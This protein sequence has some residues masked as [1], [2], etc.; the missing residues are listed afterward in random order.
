MFLK[1]LLTLLALS[2]APHS[3]LGIASPELL[4]SS[5]DT[6]LNT[7]GHLAL[8]DTSPN[9]ALLMSRDISDETSPQLTPR[10]TLTASCNIFTASSG[11]PNVPQYAYYIEIFLNGGWPAAS[12]LQ[13]QLNSNLGSGNVLQFT[14]VSGGVAFFA[15]A[16]V[17][18]EI[19]YWDSQVAASIKAFSGSASVA[20][21]PQYLGL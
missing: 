2:V 10:D 14:T 15:P 19:V 11:T 12:G 13:S 1:P 6:Q 7:A 16:L 9:P 21:T 20:V 18:Q 5:L 4:P 3:A 8:R 17:N